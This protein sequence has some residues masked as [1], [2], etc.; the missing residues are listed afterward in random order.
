MASILWNI[1]SPEMSLAPIILMCCKSICDDA[2]TNGATSICLSGPLSACGDAHMR[3]AVQVGTRVCTG[4]LLMW[5][6]ANRPQAS[7]GSGPQ[8]GDPCFTWKKK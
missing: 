6:G 8:V 5:P 4:Q 7:S 2:R 3:G 1:L